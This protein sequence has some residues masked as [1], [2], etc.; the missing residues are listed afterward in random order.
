M[1]PVILVTG[2]SGGLGASTLTAVTGTVLGR[3]RAPT[4]VDADFSGGGLDVT[5]AIE[6][7]EG[8]RW[9]DLADH[10]GH[11]DEEGLRRRLPMGPVPVLA[12]RGPTPGGPT[13]TAVVEAL[14]RVGPVV[15][16]V[17]AG[18][19]PPE[20]A[21]LADV[22]IVLVGLRPRWLRD[23]ERWALGLGELSER[24]LVVT[25]GPRRAERVSVQAADHLGLRLLEHLAD[26][27]AVPR[28]EA[29]GRAPRPRGSVGEVARA[30]V[31]ALPVSDTVLSGPAH[32]RVLGLVS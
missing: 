14:A 27:A 5:V 32:D 4:L 26:D 9:G 23:G 8:L 22:V 15:L 19:L 31:E 3:R 17:P 11:V 6:H 25:R 7:L 2:A 16:D 12:A 30:L 24:T 13:M 20:L 29:R 1:H 28:D 18:P 10:E 21:G